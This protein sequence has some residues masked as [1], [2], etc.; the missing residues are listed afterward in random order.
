MSGAANLHATRGDGMFG[1]V[2]YATQTPFG[3]ATR[4]G[5]LDADGSIVDLR[6]AYAAYLAE[7]EN[8]SQAAGIAGVRVPDTMI[9]FICGGD[10]SLDA[11]KRAMDFA[12]ARGLAGDENRARLIFPRESVRLLSPLSPGKM[13]CAGRN[14]LAHALES[15]M[16]VIEDFPRGFIKVNSTL[17][18][19]DDDVPYPMATSQFDYE[20]ELAVI[21]GRRGRDIAER[22]AGGHVYGY[23]VFN[24]LSARDWQYEERKKG[25]HLLGKNLDAT[26]PLG[27]AIVPRE[28]VPNAMALDIELRVNG[29]VRQ[30]SH[31]SQMIFSID[32]Q[33][34]HWSKMTLEPGDLIATGTP[35]GIAGASASAA[36]ANFLRPG[37]LV[38]A[39]V[40]SIGVLRN[41]IVQSVA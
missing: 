3:L 33:I 27:P 38:E 2:T 37:D 18:G 9:E 19:P 7:R 17:A 32:R 11:A 1:L 39:E 22:D 16:P 41:R 26:G 8:D 12:R 13:I 36:E 14:Y 40:A 6:G 5:G 25:N 30:K 31:T 15:A 24:D 29:V 10:H 23:A 34:A 20:V 35:E 4:L 28:F 21:I